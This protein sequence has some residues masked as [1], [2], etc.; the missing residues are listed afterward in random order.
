MPLDILIKDIGLEVLQFFLLVGASAVFFI[1]C[2]AIIKARRATV[3]VF[4]MVVGLT[5]PQVINL[6]QYS[7]DDT[8]YYLFITVYYAVWGVISIVL[9]NSIGK[10]KDDQQL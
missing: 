3:L 4:M 5:I 10:G 1:I 9:A 6:G 2:Q 8:F 7:Q